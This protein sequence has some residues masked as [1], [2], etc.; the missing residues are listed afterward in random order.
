MS[1]DQ[2]TLW[3]NI[4]SPDQRWTPREYREGGRCLHAP[5][6]CQVLSR[7]RQEDKFHLGRPAFNPNPNQYLKEKADQFDPIQSSVKDFQNVSSKC[8]AKFSDA[9]SHRARE[10]HRLLTPTVQRSAREALCAQRQRLNHL[11]GTVWMFPKIQKHLNDANVKYTVERTSGNQNDETYLFVSL[12]EPKVSE[13]EIIEKSLEIAAVSEAEEV[14]EEKENTEQEPEMKEEPSTSEVGWYKQPKSTRCWIDDATISSFSEVSD[15]RKTGLLY[16]RKEKARDASQ[17]MQASPNETVTSDY[18][19][20]PGPATPTMEDSQR[21]DQ[22]AETPVEPTARA[23]D[24]VPDE[25]LD[26]SRETSEVDERQTN[27]P[28]VGPPPYI[29]PSSPTRSHMIE[30]KRWLSRSTFS[31]ATRTMPMM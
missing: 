5:E 15:V 19:P 13:P 18:G 3:R 24:N 25:D 27:E 23:D 2:S 26:G 9:F 12:A 4:L 28:D 22:P 29:C 31:A 21:S 6:K 30:I 8:K 17:P 11:R 16:E 7:A 20:Y 1:F 10:T 14:I